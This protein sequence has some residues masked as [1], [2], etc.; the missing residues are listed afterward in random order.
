MKNSKLIIGIIV[1][2]LLILL[3]GKRCTSDSPYNGELIYEGDALLDAKDVAI[4]KVS[5]ILETPDTLIVEV[6]YAYNNAVP[7]QDVRLSV[8]PDMPYAKVTLG[9]V[10]QGEQHA[11]QVII[12]IHSSS[13]INK[14]LESYDS[15]VLKISFDRYE[16]NEVKENVYHLPVVFTKTWNPKK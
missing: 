9:H 10:E 1:L 7:A 12:N 14:G 5:K 11:S 8:A 16:N 4:H 2:V 13:M 6:H 15:N 3:L